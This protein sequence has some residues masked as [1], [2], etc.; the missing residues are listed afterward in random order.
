MPIDTLPKKYAIE[1]LLPKEF[2]YELGIYLQTCAHIE[3]LASALIVCLDGALPGDDQWFEKYAEKR[4]LPTSSLLRAL[5]D[6]AAHAQ[7]LIFRDD[8]IQLCDWLVRFVNNRHLAA[9]GAFV[10][11]SQGF[12]RVGYV[13]NLGS[14]RA[15]NYEFERTAITQLDVQAVTEDAD[16]IY[17]TLIGMI[18]RIESGLHSRVLNSAI[19]IVNHPSSAN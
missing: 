19:P 4:K 6:S 16:R 13:H 15:P 11:S 8:L 3:L 9:H 2:I 14:R 5:R 7:N 17:L 1:N 10:A 12:L 18:E